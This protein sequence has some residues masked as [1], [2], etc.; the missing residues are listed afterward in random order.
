MHLCWIT[1]DKGYDLFLMH[2]NE[3]T[4]GSKLVYKCQEKYYDSRFIC[5]SARSALKDVWKYHDFYEVKGKNDVH[6]VYNLSARFW[7]EKEENLLA[8]TSKCTIEYQNIVYS[9]E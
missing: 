4:R 2:C 3:N 8:A 7:L 9:L 1:K 5:A 6:N